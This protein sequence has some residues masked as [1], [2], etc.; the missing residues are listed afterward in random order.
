MGNDDANFT[1]LPFEQR[2]MKQRVAMIEAI[3]TMVK[4]KPVYYG[5]SKVYGSCIKFFNLEEAIEQNDMGRF[6]IFFQIHDYKS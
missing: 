6:N 3:T 1:D 2:P 5:L 4:Q